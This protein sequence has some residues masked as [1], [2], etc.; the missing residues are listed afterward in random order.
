MKRGS[1]LPGVVSNLPYMYSWPVAVTCP[2]PSS[3]AFFIG[4]SLSKP[5]IRCV[6]RE[7]YL[8][9]CLSVHM[10]YRSALFS[11]LVSSNVE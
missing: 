3:L 1:I 4:A 9:V 6:K 10:S 5:H 7:P 2:S 8:S 11:S